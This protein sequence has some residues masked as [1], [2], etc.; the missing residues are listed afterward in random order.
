M[1]F[2]AATESSVRVTLACDSLPQDRI[3][4]RPGARLGFV[5]KLI[6]LILV[7]VH[8]A[9]SVLLN[10]HLEERPDR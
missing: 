2:T 7:P 8:P 4:A 1:L 10:L 5:R 9:F 3:G 6:C